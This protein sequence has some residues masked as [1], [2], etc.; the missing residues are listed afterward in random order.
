[1]GRRIVQWGL[2]WFVR[3]DPTFRRWLQEY[4]GDWL[5][6]ELLTNSLEAMTD[7]EPAEQRRLLGRALASY[8][9]AESLGFPATTR[10]G[11]QILKLTEA[12]EETPQ[13]GLL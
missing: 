3:R 6:F 9:V 12:P 11:E 5:L 1:M 2:R 7:A 4:V 10:L 8:R 13:T